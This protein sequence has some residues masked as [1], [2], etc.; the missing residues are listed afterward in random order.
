MLVITDAPIGLVKYHVKKNNEDGRIIKTIRSSC[1]R[2]LQQPLLERV[3]YDDDGELTP[4]TYIIDYICALP[5]SEDF[6][7]DANNNTYLIVE[8]IKPYKHLRGKSN[9]KFLNLPPIQ[10]QHEVQFLAGIMEPDAW[11]YFWSEYCVGKFKSNPVKW[12][13]E[14]RYLLFLYKERGQKKFSCED[15]DFLYHKVTNAAKDYLRT[16]YTD[17]GK[18]NIS[19]MT[20][21]ELFVTFIRSPKIKSAVQKSL[22][23][24][25]PEMLTTYMMMKEAFYRAKIRL[26]EAVII[27]DYL[28]NKETTKTTTE[29]RNLFNLK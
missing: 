18:H 8:D 13:N 1:L 23:Q 3:D 25:K 2:E 19:R 24:Y 12:Y 22:E 17:K 11:H 16:M 6:K 15:L 7:Q 14:S 9:V 10:Y 5:L 26:T 27:F 28:I 20:P 21:N 4:V 29:I